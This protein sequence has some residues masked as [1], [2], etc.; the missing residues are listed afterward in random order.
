[1]CAV[2]AA[3]TARQ[4]AQR[5]LLKVSKTA[6]NLGGTK[7]ARPHRLPAVS[8]LYPEVTGLPLL[9]HAAP[10]PP[11]SARFNP[12]FLASMTEAGRALIK[13]QTLGTC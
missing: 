8:P 6:V 4:D 9:R 13:K 1:M 10:P 7:S 2:R 3:M 12:S 5:F 11:P